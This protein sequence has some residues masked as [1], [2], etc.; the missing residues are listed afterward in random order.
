MQKLPKITA[1]TLIVSM[2]ACGCSDII[3]ESGSNSK[4]TSAYTL[5]PDPVSSE[6]PPDT[7]RPRA[8]RH[9]CPRNI[10]DGNIRL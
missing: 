8:T 5:A 10:G 3:P 7:E 4:D 2:L 9:L 1:L 6:T